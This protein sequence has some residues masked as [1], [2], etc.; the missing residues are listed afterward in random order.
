MS[1]PAWVPVL[2]P[3]TDLSLKF[4]FTCSSIL[5]GALSVAF[6]VRVKQN[7]P[8]VG[9]VEVVG[10]ETSLGS[11]NLLIKNL[12]VIKTQTIA[13]IKNNL[14]FINSILAYKVLRPRFLIKIGTAARVEFRP[15]DT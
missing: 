4:N 6:W 7:S 8:E 12:P 13:I 5:Y 15:Y 11:Q 10:V 9:K 3:V 2:E 14:F 1:G